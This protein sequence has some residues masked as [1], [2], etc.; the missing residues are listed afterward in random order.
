M[1]GLH[2]VVGRNSEAYCAALL[3]NGGLRFRLRAR[4]FGGL[5][6][7][8]SS[9]SERKQVADPPYDLYDLG[10]KPDFAPEGLR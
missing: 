2:A 8:C 1:T 7:R 10:I 6:T 5:V 4:R 3:E 9:R